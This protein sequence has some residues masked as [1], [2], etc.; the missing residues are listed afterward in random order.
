VEGFF[1]VFATAIIAL[2]FTK[3]GLVRAKTAGTATLFATVV[4]LTGGILGTLHHLY[5]AG[6][7][8]GVIAIGAMVSALEVVPLVLLGLEAAENFRYSHATPWMRSY[9]WP[10]L[11]FVAVAFWNLVGAGR[12]DLRAHRH[13]GGTRQRG[14]LL[15]PLQQLISP[16][17]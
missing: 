16:C 10:V 14:Q 12:S 4:F 9:R 7:T 17:Q 6:T 5:F 1:E 3:L 13:Y 2:L 15:R 8:E 11:F